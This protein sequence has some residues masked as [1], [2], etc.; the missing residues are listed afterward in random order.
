[1]YFTRIAELLLD[2]GSTVHGCKV[3]DCTFTG[4]VGEVRA[5]LAAHKDTSDP[6]PPA[7]SQLLGLT[8][9]QLLEKAA[10]ADRI[11]KDRDRWKSRALTAERKLKSIHHALRS[12]T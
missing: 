12:A 11:T 8:T 2:D 9:A 3:T 1:M 7:R 4:S 6:A 10:A 5:H